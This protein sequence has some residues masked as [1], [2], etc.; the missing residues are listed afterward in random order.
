MQEKNS[1]I[2]KLKNEVEYY[3]NYYYKVNLKMNIIFPNSNSNNTLEANINN[4][5]SLGLNSKKNCEGEIKE[6]ISKIYFPYLIKKKINIKIVIIY[7]KINRINNDGNIN[8]NN[9]EVTKYFLPHIK[10]NNNTISNDSLN[11]NNNM[12][13]KKN[14]NQNNNTMTLNNNLIYISNSNTYQK[15]GLK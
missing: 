12:K 14:N 9:I 8:Y 15:K 10:N 11:A 6:I 7:Y 3:K 5:I 1:I 2:N 4:K 13:V